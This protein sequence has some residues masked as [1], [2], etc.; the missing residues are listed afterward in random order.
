M[1]AG[2]YVRNVLIA[3]FALVSMG[4]SCFVHL[5]GT[6]DPNPYHSCEVLSIDQSFEDYSIGVD[7]NDPRTCP[8]TPAHGAETFG[9]LLSIRRQ[10]GGGS[11]APGENALVIREPDAGGDGSIITQV[12]DPWMCP[13]GSDPDDVCT[14]EQTGSF[15]PSVTAPDNYNTADEIVRHW[16]SGAAF[17]KIS[18]MKYKFVWGEPY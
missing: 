1:I 2:A 6:P 4:L 12:Y 17:A 18:I 14:C 11:S 9:H 13:P 16:Q 10:W 5:G 7:H 8:A 15:T 3:V